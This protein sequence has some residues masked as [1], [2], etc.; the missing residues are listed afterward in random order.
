MLY[1]ISFT[2]AAKRALRKIS[3]DNRHRLIEAI[4]RLAAEPRP[5]GCTKLTD[6]SGYRIRI[7]NFRVIY[8]VDDGKLTVLVLQVGDR[9]SI[10]KK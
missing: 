1:A 2:S 8:M 7:G 5:S 10:Y 4:E 9:K 3:P 6:R